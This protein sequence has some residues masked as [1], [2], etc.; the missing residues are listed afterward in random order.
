MLTVSNV[1]TGYGHKDII[2]GVS[3]SVEK[4][5]FIA[6]IGPNGAGKTTLFRALTG[7]LPLSG[8]DV[9][10]RGQDT[11]RITSREFARDVSAM[12]QAVDAPFSFTVEEFVFLARFAHIGR[13]DRPKENDFNAVNEAFSLT[14]TGNLRNRSISELSGGER[15]RV[16]L[17][18]CFAQKPALLFLDEPT[19]HLDITH[20]ISIMNILKK[21]NEEQAV[22]II[23]ILHDLNLAAEYCRQLIL[24]DNGK[25]FRK[26][27]PDEVITNKCIREVYGID[28][29]IQKNP[30]SGKPF[31]LMNK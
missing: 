25:I 14:D 4:G 8:G 19:A 28:V 27:E 23:V 11:R 1:S 7:V 30:V 2:K 24:L 18:Q 15:Q 21:L 17:A 31:L 3:F 6:V 29:L 20:Q 9:F 10:Y 12:P 22:T 26:G 16:L 13:F 5:D